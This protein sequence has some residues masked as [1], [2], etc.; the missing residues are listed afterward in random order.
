[1]AERQELLGLASDIVSAHI[2]N[3]AVAAERL[4][5]LIQQ[6]FK[7]LAGVKQATTGPSRPESAVPVKKSV[8]ADSIICLDCGKHFSML[9]RHLM[10]YHQ[11]TPE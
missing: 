3:N 8:L 1:M 2:S 10:T 7:T 4:P 11:L 9:K 6:V 5:A